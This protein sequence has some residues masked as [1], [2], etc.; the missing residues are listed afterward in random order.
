MT[1]DWHPEFHQEQSPE[2]RVQGR[3]I[4]D[5]QTHADKADSEQ[6]PEDALI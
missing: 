6:Y 2:F 3:I 5:K 4:P 1:Q